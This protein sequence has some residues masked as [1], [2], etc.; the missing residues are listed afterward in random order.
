MALY[1]G[2]DFLGVGVVWH[3]PLCTYT[4]GDG[5]TFML[6]D[7]VRLVDWG[8]GRP[9]RCGANVFFA[10]PQ[11][12]GAQRGLDAWDFAWGEWVRVGARRHRS[13][14]GGMCQG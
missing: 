4:W 2:D 11:R 5:V 12:P 3:A 9:L 13:V 8:M 7:E 14:P 10:R 1:R 6:A